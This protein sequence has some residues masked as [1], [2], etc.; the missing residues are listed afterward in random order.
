LTDYWITNAKGENI[1]GPFSHFYKAQR[2]IDDHENMTGLRIQNFKPIPIATTAPLLLPT[3]TQV[4]KLLFGAKGITLPT[5]NPTPPPSVV[6][7]NPIVT[8]LFSP[9]PSPVDTIPSIG[10]GTGLKIDPMVG[11]RPPSGTG[12]SGVNQTDFVD[13]VIDL[14]KGQ[15]TDQISNMLKSGT[16]TAGEKPSNQIIDTIQGQLFTGG[17]KDTGGIQG[18]LNSTIA[19]LGLL[20]GGLIALKLIK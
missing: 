8:P 20:F 2:Y 12:I 6:R 17:V 14:T 4:D 3:L 18:I 9:T 11:L 7:I 5:V 19:P 1:S 10:A 13:N 15:V 16:Q